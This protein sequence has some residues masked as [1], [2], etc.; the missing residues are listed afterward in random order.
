MVCP[1]KLLKNENICTTQNKSIKR[2][3]VLKKKKKKNYDS[4]HKQQ[5]EMILLQQ[6]YFEMIFA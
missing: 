1:T 6:P 4:S 3:V 5:I 2:V